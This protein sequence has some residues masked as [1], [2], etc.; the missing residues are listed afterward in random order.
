MDKVAT[1]V[2]N[3]EIAGRPGSRGVRDLGTLVTL[4]GNQPKSN[5]LLLVRFGCKSYG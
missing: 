2:T 4:T 5:M 1:V 3:R